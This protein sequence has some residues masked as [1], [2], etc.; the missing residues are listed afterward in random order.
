MDLLVGSIEHLW[1]P[2][3]WQAQE[4][5]TFGTDCSDLL[6][7]QLQKTKS[8]STAGVQTDYVLCTSRVETPLYFL[9]TLAMMSESIVHA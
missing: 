3:A 5:T 7:E 4:E 6:S 2:L 1:Q 8:E 9:L